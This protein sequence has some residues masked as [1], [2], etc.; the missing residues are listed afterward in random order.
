MFPSLRAL[1]A[2]LAAVLPAGSL[3]QQTGN[4]FERLDKNDG[5]Y[6]S[7]TELLAEVAPGSGWIAVARNQDGRISRGEFE[8]VTQALRAPVRHPVEPDEDPRGAV[9]AGY[10]AQRLIGNEVRDREGQRI[11][12]VRKPAYRGVVN[13]A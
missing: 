10:S 12:R 6:L 8:A 4:L 9:S 11:G 2:A 13:G 7:T 3:R 5:G 1:L